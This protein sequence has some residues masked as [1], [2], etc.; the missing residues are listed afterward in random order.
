[1]RLNYL[2]QGMIAIVPEARQLRALAAMMEAK[3]DL[4]QRLAITTP[5]ALRAA[6]WKTGE[7]R[8]VRETINALFDSRPRFSARI[9]F[10]GKQSF[11]AGAGVVAMAFGALTNDIVLNLLHITVSLIYFAAVLIRGWALFCTRQ[12]LNDPPSPDRNL[13]V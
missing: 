12:Q 6:V 13:P 4:S 8:R 9:V 5:S 11:L 2:T 1:L 10:S 3:P 7:R